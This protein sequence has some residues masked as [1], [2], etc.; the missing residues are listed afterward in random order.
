MLPA[1][2]ESHF[3]KSLLLKYSPVDVVWQWYF[4]EYYILLMVD[5]MIYCI[6]KTTEGSQELV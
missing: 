3:D 2:S 1:F 4:D 6:Y 5:H